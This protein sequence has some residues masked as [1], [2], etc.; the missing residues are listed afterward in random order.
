VCGIFGFAPAD[1][2]APVVRET[3]DAM[4]RTLRHRGPD[5]AGFHFGPGV[6][7]GAQRL[8]VVDLEGG[9]QPLRNEDGAIAVV[10]NGEIYNAPELRQALAGGGH[11]FATR[12]DVEPIAHLYEDH[13]AEC[14]VR[15][16]GM[17]GF[18]L[19]DAR[20][21]RLLLARDRMGIK[22][23][24]YAEGPEGLWFASEQ[25]AIVAA[26]GPARRLNLRALDDLFT[27]GFVRAPDTL[28][29]GVRQLLPGQY[30]IY[31]S[32]RVQLRSYWDLDLSATAD[33][34]RSAEEWASAVRATLEDAVRV[35]LR[36]DVPVGA[37]LSPGI[38]SSAVVALMTR[39]GGD[40]ETFSLTFEGAKTDEVAGDDVLARFGD[41]VRNHRV[42]CHLSDFALMPQVLWH[43]EDPGT[44]G[45]EIPRFV[46]ARATAGR[47]KVVLTG[48]G[49][50]EL[51]GGYPWFRFHDRVERLQWLPFALRRALG[52]A[53]RGLGRTRASMLLTPSATMD[54]TRYSSFVGLRTGSGESSLLS[55]EVRAAVDHL[56][57]RDGDEAGADWPPS[58]RLHY[59]DA[60]VFMPNV[61]IPALDR[62]TMAHSLEAR[63]PF[64]D[65][66][67]VELCARI[68]VSFKRPRPIE[69]ALLR[70]ALGDLLPAPTLARRKRAFAAPYRAWLS[71]ELP[72]FATE[73]LSVESLR[74]KGYFDPAAVAATLT[75]CRQTRGAGARHLLA[76]L[77]VQLWD[78][79]FLGGHGGD[80][81]ES[82]H[83]EALDQRA[84]SSHLDRRHRP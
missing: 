71:G 2:H 77:G 26:R 67:L 4:A 11:W 72:A 9:N 53:A 8:A 75:R 36:S 33:P 56:A 78:D 7:L 30:L 52:L 22:P 62:A 39:M 50:D 63:V 3:I 70:G 27:F 13:G 42:P 74:R 15:L 66:K 24:Y 34:P 60:R 55:P 25:K 69:K 16:R 32:G 44:L 6:G 84:Q 12:S 54:L 23:L 17:F 68:P 59:Y 37:W 45:L 5:G 31:E 82:L 64:L 41:R 79:L 48:E 38:D 20:A 65:D 1:G 80:G 28:L 10:C 43:A 49:S 51:F 29:D 76:V 18:A 61:V 19:W 47:L 73:L 81:V 14:V 21:R 58:A 57:E 40:V 83:R 35:H 46:L